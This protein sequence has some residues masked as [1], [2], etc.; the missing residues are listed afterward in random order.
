MN[1]AA[2]ALLGFA[3]ISHWETLPGCRTRG[4]MGRLIAALEPPLR[5]LF[6][7]SSGG[8]LA[9]GAVLAAVLPLG[10][11]AVSALALWLCGRIHPSAALRWRRSGAGRHWP[12]GV[13]GMK[14]Q[15]VQRADGRHAGRCPARGFPH[16][17]ARH[18]GIER[19][20]RDKS[21]GGD[22]GGKF[23][24][25]CG[26]ACLYMLLGGAPLALCYKAVNTM[27]SMVGYKTTAI[28]FL[29][30]P[31]PDWTMRPTISPPVWQRCI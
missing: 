2:A 19:R 22:C 1:I 20:G 15:S 30:A 10:T 3:W 17:G 29:A 23:F 7:K 18:A 16:C 26:G 8:Q 12:C 31:R 25:R 21:G 28:Y 14:P 4:G 24:R 6:P 9:A 13:C 11:L 27:D 5:R